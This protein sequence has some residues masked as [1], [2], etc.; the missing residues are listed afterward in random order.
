MRGELFRIDALLFLIIL[1]LFPTAF[2][3]IF[4]FFP[5]LSVA[6]SVECR[7]PCN[8]I[9]V[10]LEVGSSV[11]NIVYDFCIRVANACECLG[12]WQGSPRGG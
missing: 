1:L 9:R 11:Q 2:Y 5:S 10:L 6:E 3:L 4:F 12:E 7:N 8:D